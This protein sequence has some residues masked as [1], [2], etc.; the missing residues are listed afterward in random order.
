MAN[1]RPGVASARL[2]AR[3]NRP[4]GRKIIDCSDP[5]ALQSR[6]APAQQPVE[7]LDSLAHCL[8]QTSEVP[9]IKLSFRYNVSNIYDGPS[10]TLCLNKGISPMGRH[11]KLPSPSV[12]YTN[13]ICYQPSMVNIALD[14][15]VF[16]KKPK[17][18]NITNH[19]IIS[20]GQQTGSRMSYIYIN[21]K[22][23]P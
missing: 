6:P 14:S 17:T 3:S 1:R 22:K 4:A 13:D 15:V 20:H 11:D 9:N 8:L 18:T 10:L 7:A 5:A 2:T 19:E 23:L 21:V 12:R 16:E